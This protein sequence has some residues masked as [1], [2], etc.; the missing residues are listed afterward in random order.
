MSRPRKPALL[1]SDHG[2]FQREAFTRDDLAPLPES[3]RQDLERLFLQD[4]K[5]ERK[6]YNA[7]HLAINLARIELKQ[8]PVSQAEHKAA[9]EEQA[10][11]AAEMLEFIKPPHRGAGPTYLQWIIEDNLE[12]NTAEQFQNDPLWNN[13]NLLAELLAM[14]EERST[15]LADK[16]DPS[17]YRKNNPQH[18]LAEYLA[19]AAKDGTLPMKYSA[20]TTSRLASLFSW[21]CDHIGIESGDPAKYLQ[22]K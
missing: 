21:C 13:R 10:R 16:I 4:A 14:I 8:A 20:S 15:R 18:I 12:Q 11:R 3:A 2:N 22:D 1:I 9:L 6:A 17:A 5:D 19:K 7:V